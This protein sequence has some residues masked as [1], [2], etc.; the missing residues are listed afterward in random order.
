MSQPNNNPHSPSVSGAMSEQT[1]SMVETTLVDTLGLSM[2]NA[3]TSQ[4]NAQITT[5]ASITNACARLLQAGAPAGAPAA[6]PQ[7]A[8]PAEPGTPP[9]QEEQPPEEKKRFSMK[10]L[11]NKDNK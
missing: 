6:S 5:A 3:V 10:S 11:L 4:Q 7:E 1:T 8:E 9:T 2:H